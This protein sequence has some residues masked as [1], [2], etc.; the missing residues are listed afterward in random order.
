MLSEQLKDCRKIKNVT[1]R[2]VAD[3]LG[4]TLGAYQ[5]YEMGTREP[6]IST[7]N[8][9]ADYFNVSLDY[10]LGRSDTREQPYTPSE[11]SDPHK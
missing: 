4:V 7:L 8:K 10:L 3:F 1:Q 5:R 9:L 2:E 11:V 6:N